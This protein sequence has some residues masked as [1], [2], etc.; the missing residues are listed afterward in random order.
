VSTIT[1]Q[2]PIARRT[3]PRLAGLPLCAVILAAVV[4]A[5]IAIGAK[6]IPLSDVVGGLFGDDGSES[7]AIV[8]ELR[9]PR[10][11]VGL[12][13]G[14]ALGLAGALMQALTRNPLADPGILGVEAG[15]AAAI[16]AAIALFG[17]TE[18]RAYIWFSFLGAAVASVVVY[19][20]GSHGRAGATPVRLALAGVAVT[21]ALTAFTNG[22]ILLDP[23]A[24]D[25]FRHWVVGSLA[26]RD[27]AIL[28]EVGPF[29]IVGTLIALALARPLNALALGDD[30]GRA[31]GARVGRTRV[32]GA[33]SITLLCGAATAVA[34][35]IV[36]VGLCV[37]HMA[38][39]IAGPDQRW[40]L[41]YSAL[42]APILL[43]TADV[44]GRVVIS[45]SELEVGVVTALI[46]APV[47]IALV[48]RKR[49]AQL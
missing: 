19:V 48:R 11:L 21:A 1:T 24:F 33:V 40:V 25:E 39:A 13:V 5:S 28:A 47:F 22:L 29:L 30:S 14:V 44:I 26:G 35:P 37:P 42:L 45:P 8:R 41:G 31:L 7:A 16:V 12:A 2:I 10:T 34:G 17:V 18:P 49:I 23:E 15:A 32:L 9:V 46:G 3:L 38:R 20:L 27:M 43:L 6:S 4:M 36:F